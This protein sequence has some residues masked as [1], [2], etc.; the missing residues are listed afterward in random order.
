MSRQLVVR[1]DAMSIR[2]RNLF[3]N[4]CS[5]YMQRSCT[6]GYNIKREPRERVSIRIALF[7][8]VMR[9]HVIPSLT[10]AT[11]PYNTLHASLKQIELQ[12]PCMLRRSTV[13]RFQLQP[14]E[15]WSSCNDD[16][17]HFLHCMLHMQEHFSSGMHWMRLV[18]R[19]NVHSG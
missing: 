5:Q 7:T 18:Y 14:Q 4:A 6:H 1:T 9:F 11:T 2:Y 8:C 16:D 12:Y 3:V 15:Q 19:M 13:Q 10:G 17:L